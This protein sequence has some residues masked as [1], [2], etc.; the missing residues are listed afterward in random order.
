MFYFALLKVL[1][2]TTLCRKKHWLFLCQ[3][4]SQVQVFTSLR[5][6]SPWPLSEHCNTI[7]PF[8]VGKCFAKSGFSVHLSI[9]ILQRDQP[10]YYEFRSKIGMRKYF[11]KCHTGLDW[12]HSLFNVILFFFLVTFFLPYYISKSLLL[13][14]SCHFW[15][16]KAKHMN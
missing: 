14:V 15:H 5:A 11:S 6:K 13:V 12:F 10:S 3:R 9:E 1:E 7:L 8:C 2:G 16:Q 4:P